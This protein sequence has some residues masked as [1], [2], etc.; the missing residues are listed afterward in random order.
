LYPDTALTAELLFFSLLFAGAL[1]LLVSHHTRGLRFRLVL[2]VAFAI[3]GAAGVGAG[4]L[5]NRNA[6]LPLGL[7]VLAC[8]LVISRFPRFSLAGRLFLTAYVGMLVVFIGWGIEF[9]LAIPVSGI[10]R[11]LLFA[12]YPLLVITF[13]S[14]VLQSLTDWEPLLRCSWDRTPAPGPVG[15]R[16]THPKVSLHVPACAEP[17]ELVIATLD[18]LAVLE[19]PNYEV[20]V[21]DNNTRD[22]KLWRPVAAHCRELGPRFRF[23]HLEQWPGAKA[24]ALNFALE[25]TAP[26][27]EVVGVIDADYIADPDFLIRLI[28]HFDDPRMGFVQTPHDYR[29]WE[30]SLYLRMCYWEYRYFFASTM[31]ALNEHDAALTVGTMCLIRRRALEEAGG[32]AEWCATEDSELAIRI[33]ACGYTSQYLPATFG[34]GLIPQTFGGYK[35]QRFRWTSGPIQ[36]LKHHVRLF[37]PR[38]LPVT[39]PSSLTP[40]QK[41][42]H[43]NHGLDRLN[44]G[45]QLLVLPI[46][47]AAVGSMI[48]HHEVV[49]VPSALWLV[50]TVTLFGGWVMWW[51]PYRVLLRARIPDVLGAFVASKALVHTITMSAAKS[52]FTSRIPWLRTN[53]FPALPLGL[54]ALA[55]ARTELLLSFVLISAALS[56]MLLLPHPGLLLLLAIGGF[57]QGLNYLAAPAMALLAERDVATESSRPQTASPRE[58]SALGRGQFTLSS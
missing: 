25:Q 27:A 29:D 37:L 24:G 45:F 8:A 9:L 5:T 55:D 26:D 50:S 19:Y 41:L 17:P 11:A 35:R 51:L 28:G 3:L 15:R 14:G 42:L 16:A 10:T 54:G 1:A 36:E 49:P 20:L 12:G 23:F 31:V 47:A 44:V 39:V 6:T 18:A 22:P 57:Y 2:P 4:F 46:G 58:P 33:H 48:W 13:P 32:W 56:A 34:R 30:N 40:I 7:S 43:L 53:K 38:G 52:V 21:I